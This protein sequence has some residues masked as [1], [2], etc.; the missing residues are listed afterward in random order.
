[1]AGGD[2]VVAAVP[3]R[4]TDDTLHRLVVVEGLVGGGVILALVLLGWVV[5]RIGLRP[6]ERIGR[7]AS[8]IAAAT[9]PGG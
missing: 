4:E 3:L 6:L 7:V 5:I 2:T 8:E 1:M 9:S